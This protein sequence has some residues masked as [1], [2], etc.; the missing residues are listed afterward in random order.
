MKMITV[1]EIE[2]RGDREGRP[3][4]AFYISFVGAGDLDGPII[5]LQERLGYYRKSTPPF[6]AI[7]AF[8]VSPLKKSCGCPITD[9]RGTMVYSANRGVDR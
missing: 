5:S 2:S 3:C 4:F 6:M 8:I 9:I 7:S 1:Y